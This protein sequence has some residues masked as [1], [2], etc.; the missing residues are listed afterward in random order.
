MANVLSQKD[1]Q[2][3]LAGSSSDIIASILGQTNDI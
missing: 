1:I 3:Q 2:A